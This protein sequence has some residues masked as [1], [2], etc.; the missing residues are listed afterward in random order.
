[1]VNEGGLSL[2]TGAEPGG[3]TRSLGPRASDLVLTHVPRG[4]DPGARLGK[5]GPRLFWRTPRFGLS[6][7]CLVERESGGS[8]ERI[9][10][11]E[12]RQGEARERLEDGRRGEGMS[13]WDR[14]LN[15]ARALGSECTLAVVGDH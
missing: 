10:A 11:S 2:I 8:G 7:S 15:T 12:G 13:W 6:G 9:D 5:K 3:T 14:A 4:P 1:M